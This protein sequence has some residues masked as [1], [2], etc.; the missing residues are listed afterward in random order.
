MKQKTLCIFQEGG[1]VPV[2]LIDR[3][4]S[5]PTKNDTTWIFDR[6]ET[7]IVASLPQNE[8]NPSPRPGLGL[9]TKLTII[10]LAIMAMTLI[11]RS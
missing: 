8:L 3:R 4:S 5:S 6:K 11:N 7:P 1:I 2:G 10:G 9:G